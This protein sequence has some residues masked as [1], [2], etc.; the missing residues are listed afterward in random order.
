M[1]PEESIKPAQP[2]RRTRKE[3]VENMLPSF[4]PGGDKRKRKAPA[5]GPGRKKTLDEIRAA[6]MGVLDYC[7]GN[8]RKTSALTGVP[9]NTVKLWRDGFEFKH[10]V[11]VAERRETRRQIVDV[12]AACAESL[13]VIMLMKA[14]D[15]TVAE[16]GYTLAKMT[17]ATLQRAAMIKGKL[18]PEEVAAATE[19]PVEVPPTPVSDQMVDEEETAKWEHIVTRVMAQAREAGKAISREAAVAAVLAK[20]PESHPYLG[21]PET[22]EAVDSG[23]DETDGVM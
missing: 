19:A 12:M 14:K 11:E 2:Q 1:E 10:L 7:Q 22:E 21:S 16:I 4:R 9:F 23:P 6:V 3:A 20:R 18:K 8:L 15:A 5:R 17:E 13:A